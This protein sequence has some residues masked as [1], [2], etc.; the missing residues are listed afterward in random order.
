M[1]TTITYADP[2]VETTF[3]DSAETTTVTDGTPV[4]TTAPT[5]N[6]VDTSN[7]DGSVTRKTYTT[8]VTT[9]TTP[10]TTLVSKVRTYTDTTKKLKPLLQQPHQIL[11]STTPMAL[12][13]MSQEKLPLQVLTSLKQLAQQTEQ[14]LS[15]CPHPLKILLP[16]LQPQCWSAQK[17]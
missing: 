12:I 9:T 13:E 17:Q 1:V 6:V 2:Y 5:N 3:T 7:A 15:Q 4:V 8:T 16:L 14:K 10:R 11:K